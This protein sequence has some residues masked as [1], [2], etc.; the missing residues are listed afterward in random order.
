[1]QLNWFLKNF[2]FPLNINFIVYFMSPLLLMVVVIIL[3]CIFPVFFNFV[4]FRFG[5]LFFFCFL[6]IRV[7]LLMGIG[8]GSNSNYSLIGAIRRIAQTISYEVSLFLI[9]LSLIFLISSYRLG[10]FFLFQDL[11]RLVYLRLFIFF[12]LMGFYFC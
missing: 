12:C 1:M 4:N 2:F 8:W 10:R 11:I 9:F 6:S 7:Y 5:G 3:W